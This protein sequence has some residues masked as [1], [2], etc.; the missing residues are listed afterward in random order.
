MSRE[1]IR[2][3]FPTHKEMDLKW[4]S[5][6]HP[7]LLSGLIHEYQELAEVTPDIRR[8]MTAAY[9]T[10]YGSGH[11]QAIPWNPKWTA[12]ELQIVIS[13][14][15]APRIMEVECK[16]LNLPTDNLFL[17]VES[18][19]KI[20]STNSIPRWERDFLQTHSEIDCHSMGLSCL[21]GLKPF[22]IVQPRVTF[23]KTF[24]IRT[25]KPDSLF[26]SGRIYVVWD[27]STPLYACQLVHK[28]LTDLR[29]TML[30]TIPVSEAL[31]IPVH[32]LPGQP[33]TFPVA[34]TF[35]YFRSVQV[36][37]DI[38]T[39]SFA[40][41]N[42][43]MQQFLTRIS[44]SG[45][46]T[47]FLSSR[48][49]TPIAYW[50][51][52]PSTV[53]ETAAFCP[54]YSGIRKYYRAPTLK[55]GFLFGISGTGKTYQ[56]MKYIMD[57]TEEKLPTLYVLTAD[58]R[59]VIETFVS[60]RTETKDI[61][62][63]WEARDLKRYP[64][65]GQKLILVNHTLLARS[66]MLRDRFAKMT[67]SRLVLDPFETT[68]TNHTNGF[69]YDKIWLLTSRMKPELTEELFDKLGLLDCFVV[70]F[71][72]KHPQYPLM[73]SALFR[74]LG[75][76]FT[77]TSHLSIT[78]PFASL[79]SVCSHRPADLL[80][81][82]RIC[83]T[84]L[85]VIAEGNESV[86]A[87]LVHFLCCLEAGVPFTD[88]E[89]DQSLSDIMYA[90]RSRDSPDV[91]LQA[92]NELP[93]QK[94]EVT[95]A[96]E[97][98]CSICFM[99]F[100]DPVRNQVCRH[101]FCHQCMKEWL[102]RDV[103]CPVCRQNLTD[104]FVAV[105]FS[106]LGKRKRDNDETPVHSFSRFIH[107]Q[108]SETLCTMLSKD[109]IL[110]P[111]IIFTHYRSLVPKYA[112]VI[113]LRS[114]RRVLELPRKLNVSELQSLRKTFDQFDTFVVLGENMSLFA[115]DHRFKH[116]YLMDI[117]GQPD[118]LISTYNDFRHALTKCFFYTHGTFHHMIFHDVNHYTNKFG[119][120]VDMITGFRPKK[121]LTMYRAFLKT[122]G[123]LP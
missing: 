55:G 107:N 96:T 11:A 14:L 98:T 114:T 46:L 81:L 42:Y 53:S 20:I 33:L 52:H 106:A 17:L 49:A 86:S 6:L 58:D 63:Y 4:E 44:C 47:T 104:E 5:F 28:I 18:Q 43:K 113:K 25:V 26:V 66:K 45:S 1:L 36:A 90:L 121:M 29:V 40:F 82:H 3:L 80:P 103:R 93:T 120:N 30:P 23:I 85:S 105:L 2:T 123:I 21:S 9:R 35:D 15:L 71:R 100:E 37:S 10:K 87:R 57:Q 50:L 27:D 79:T 88:S 67:F 48:E 59:S 32:S 83:D 64:L 122:V 62:A 118:P 111:T 102:R 91:H 119:N 65:A 94:L 99:T 19:P 92:I 95:P 84:L 74:T 7:S 112:A 76:A 61:V 13:Q 77:D 68:S 38:L 60:H 117:I 78:L 51:S 12:E 22:L 24:R 69:I 72:R 108:R 54:Y 115:K 110:S 8:W 39:T 16:R 34:C 31:T 101:I 97:T 75:M 70:G 56:M 109:T 89:M 116:V 73:Q 41:S